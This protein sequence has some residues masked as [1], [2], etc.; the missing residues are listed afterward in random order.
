MRQRGRILGHWLGPRIATQVSRLALFAAFLSL[1]ATGLGTAAA[2]H[3]HARHDLDRLLLVAAQAGSPPEA[4]ANGHHPGPVLVET[5]D[6]AAPTAPPAALDPLQ[7]KAALESEEP[8]FLDLGSRR[9]LLLAVESPQVHQQDPPPD[10]EHLLRV[11]HAHRE[12][13]WSTVGPFLTIYAGISAGVLLGGILLLPRA[14]AHALAPLEE[15]RAALEQIHTFTAHRRLPEG[16]PEEVRSLVA[17]V[18]ALLSRLESAV[19]AQTRF[20]SVAAHEL[21]TPVALLRAELEL[22]LRRPRSP[23]ELAQALQG[24]HEST[25]RMSRLV[26]A[27]M[28]LARVEAGQLEEGRRPEH[29]SSLLT[30]AINQEKPA[31]EAAGCSL[32]LHLQGDPTLQA[33]PALF[34]AAVA[35][36]LR[37][38]A[39]HAPGTPVSLRT[40]TQ[41][42]SPPRLHLSIA[43]GGPG[44]DT[45]ARPR[46]L[47]LG[48]RF[49]TKVIE[50]HGGS[51][52][53]GP[54]PLGGLQVTLDLPLNEEPG[55]APPTA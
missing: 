38:C 35:N 43:D 41:A 5:W 9:V 3:Q 8:T 26:E 55:N 16:G 45:H 29:L 49:T 40:H 13:P 27:M 25:L 54:S 28:A 19:E 53:L 46:G 7:A 42:G 37:N 21:R 24:A 30:A 2:L 18:N 11:A 52:H 44:L 33:H 48:L 31:M 34:T 50:R 22:A 32:Q 47:G 17:S 20:T 36:L 6:P 1:A 10:H 14:L 12:S 51:L 23:E 39:V 15:T 4:W